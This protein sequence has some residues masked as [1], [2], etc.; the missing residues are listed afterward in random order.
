VTDFNLPLVASFKNPP[1][2][3][4]KLELLAVYLPT[5]LHRKYPNAVREWIWQYAFPADKLSP[6]RAAAKSAGT[7]CWRRTCKTP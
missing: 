6:V 7:R 3:P 2:P 5:A 1:L 4:P